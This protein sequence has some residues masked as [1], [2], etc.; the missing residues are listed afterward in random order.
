MQLYAQP[1]AEV[2]S[3]ITPNFYRMK[4]S[5]DAILS[6]VK[7]QKGKGFKA[8]KRWEKYWDQRVFPDGSFPPA[9]LVQ[10][11]WELYQVEKSLS[12]LIPG[13]SWTSLGPNSSSGGYAGIGRIK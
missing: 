12:A 13:S 3:T 5:G 2:S 7:T 1:W 6:E 9:N 11:N 4:V 10:K 8:F